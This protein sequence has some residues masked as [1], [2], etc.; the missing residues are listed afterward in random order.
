MWIQDKEKFLRR[1]TL[2]RSNTRYQDREKRYGMNVDIALAQPEICI[3][4]WSSPEIPLSDLQDPTSST[5]SSPGS[6]LTP[7]PA[8]NPSSA[9]SSPLAACTLD[10]GK[11]SMGEKHTEVETI[12]LGNE[13]AAAINSQDLVGQLPLHAEKI[14]LTFE[15]IPR[16]P[17][18]H[19]AVRDFFYDPPSNAA[20]ASMVPLPLFT[21]SPSL[22]SSGF[23]K[24]H[25]TRFSLLPYPD[26]FD[27][28]MYDTR[29]SQESSIGF[30]FSFL[31]GDVTVAPESPVVLGPAT[32]TYRDQY[33]NS[34]YSRLNGLCTPTKT[35]PVNAKVTPSSDRIVPRSRK[36]LG[37][38]PLAS[39]SF[40]TP[41]RIPRTS[42]PT[43][44]KLQDS[45][46][47]YSSPNSSGDWNIMSLD[48]VSMR[49]REACNDLSKCVWTEE[50]FLRII[51][52]L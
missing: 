7:T 38:L 47:L 36:H 20:P 13:D 32:V 51:S 46:S 14:K 29:A 1:P 25:N 52:P 18:A 11:D 31:P 9:P 23:S 8:E 19:S 34:A 44:L 26:L 30:C 28:A 5:V 39:I 21:N 2:T 4:D 48:E 16:I 49:L 41:T 22:E 24:A 35:N 33:R 43:T 50:E 17:N 27:F 3:E 40:N 37:E 10:F 6:T 15:P 42:T 12:S 45:L